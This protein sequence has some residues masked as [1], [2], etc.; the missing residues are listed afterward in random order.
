MLEGGIE[1]APTDKS[2]HVVL[3]DEV[4]CLLIGAR[5]RWIA[6]DSIMRVLGLASILLLAPILAVAQ[7]PAPTPRPP[8]PTPTNIRDAAAVLAAAPKAQ[9]GNGVL[10]ATVLL[11]AKDDSFYRGMRFDPSGMLSSVKYGDQEY[12]GLWFDKLAENVRDWVFDKGDVVASANTGALGPADLFDPDT[13]PGWAE[14]PAGGAF[15]KIGAGVLRKPAGEG[16]YNLATVYERVN[17]GVW[18][19]VAKKDRVEFTHTVSD[20]ASGHGYVYR[21]VVRLVPNKP[22]LRIE[23]SLKNTGAKA[24]ST[25]TYN[26]NFITFGGAAPTGPGLTLSTR[27]DIAAGTL[28][29]VAKVA[30][31][32]LTLQR[33]L[34]GEQR[35]Y[36]P[37]GGFP[38]GA[39]PYDV[40][41]HNASGA[42]F[43]VVGDRPMSKL[44]LWSF[45]RTISAE[46]Y[47]NLQ[48][49]PGKSAAWNLEY[50]YASGAGPAR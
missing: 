16:A 38:D 5:R 11:P 49:A 31:N 2:C 47:V 39:G 13:P 10:T 14:L 20:P 36:S 43:R 48:I 35:I 1:H 25:T 50:T 27:Y 30:G 46:P 23:H 40:G 6:E 29:D 22:M 24:I 28:T 9:I 37:I 32:K 33:A 18:K 42:G 26:H 12:Y 3:A 44:V 4:E 15:L 45:R 19:V 7:A 8:Q 41:L 17:P 34:T 21:K